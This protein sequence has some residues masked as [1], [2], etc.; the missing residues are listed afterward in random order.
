MDVKQKGMLMILSAYSVNGI[1]NFN[2]KDLEVYCSHNVVTRILTELEELGE[3]ERLSKNG[4]LP[5]YKI[6]SAISFG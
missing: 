4:Y 5:R 6:N 1:A 2:I 3:I